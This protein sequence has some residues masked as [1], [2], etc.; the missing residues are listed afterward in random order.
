MHRFSRL[1]LLALLALVTGFFP[2]LAPTPHRI[3]QV[4]FELIQ[5]G[6]TK[7]QVEAIFGVPCGQY[8]WAEAEP[9]A[10]WSGSFSLL[11]GDRLFVSYPASGNL[12]SL[13][14][15]DFVGFYTASERWVSRHG[16]FVIHFDGDDRV[17]GKGGDGGVRIVPPWQRWWKA[18]SE[19]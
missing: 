4:H 11:S 2:L 17:V 3:D 6:M 15:I 5:A 7:S 14:V 10:L 8:D 13:G 9:P 12:G 1:L 19:R 18:I 16:E